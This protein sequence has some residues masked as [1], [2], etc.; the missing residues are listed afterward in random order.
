MLYLQ[1]CGCIPH[2]VTTPFGGALVS[3]GVLK[4]EIAI[5]GAHR[6]IKANLKTNDNNEL[7][8]AA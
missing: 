8:F 5:R 4:T 7:A 3:T 1:R 2:A 6:V